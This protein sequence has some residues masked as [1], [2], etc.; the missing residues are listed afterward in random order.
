MSRKN[1]NRVGLFGTV[2]HYEKGKK[3]GEARPS[4]FGGSTLYDNHGRKVGESR[5]GLFLQLPL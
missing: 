4:L 3:I 5:V 1:E 2:S